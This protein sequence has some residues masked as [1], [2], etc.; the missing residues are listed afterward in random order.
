[1]NFKMIKLI[2]D[3]LEEDITS[4][5]IT[6]SKME[7]RENIYRAQIICKQDCVVAGLEVTKKVFEILDNDIE[8]INSFRDGEKAHLKD[9]VLEFKSKAISIL[10]GERTALNFLQRMSGIAT[11][12]KRLVNL[13]K[14]YGVRITDTRK[15]TPNFRIFE[16]EAVKIGGGTNHR[17]NLSD[18]VLIK[19]NHI[20]IAGSIKDAIKQ[21]KSSLS[22]TKKIEVEV[23]N[24][25]E[26]K[27]AIDSKVD[28][29]MLDNFPDKGLK[30]TISL[31]PDN[32]T[33]EVSG[34]INEDNI[35]R[36]AQAGPDVISLGAITHSYRS[37]DFSL[38]ILSRTMY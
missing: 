21:V 33:V 11:L 22:H 26:L 2:Q 36:V 35:V 38:K 6:T 8:I 34:N 13:I 16:K 12:T 5:D 14:N 24:M 4:G 17:Y 9:V 31:I 32:I 3:A 7:N 27:V 18:A 19:D 37:I 28:I 1:M 10:R 25:D 30:E 29:I 15:T 20:Q 23:K